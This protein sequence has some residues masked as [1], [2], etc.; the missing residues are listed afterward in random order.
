MLAQADALCLE[1]RFEEAATIYQQLVNMAESRLGPNHPDAILVLQRLADSL[2]AMNLFRDCLPLYE[3]LC[4][5]ARSMLGDGDPDVVNLMFKI[6]KTQELIGSFTEARATYQFAIN[7]AT[8]N[9]PPGHELTT[10]LRQ[11][12]DAL[13]QLME[14]NIQAAQAWKENT[15]TNPIITIGPDGRPLGPGKAQAPLPPLPQMPQQLPPGVAPPQST[16][17]PPHLQPRAQGLTPP[18]GYEPLPDA[19]YDSLIS[20]AAH[21]NGASNSDNSPAAQSSHNGGQQP[22]HPAGSPFGDQNQSAQA[23]DNSPQYFKAPPVMAGLSAPPPVM[24]ALTG[25]ASNANPWDP[26][27]DAPPPGMNDG[28]SSGGSPS[29]QP[30]LPPMAQSSGMQPPLSESPEIQAPAYAGPPQQMPQQPPPG[31]PPLPQQMPFPPQPQSLP[32]QHQTLPPQQMQ[33]EMQQQNLPSQQPTVPPHLMAMAIEMQQKNLSA[34]QQTVPP[35]QMPVEMQQQ[36]N[37]PGQQQTVPPHLMPQMQSAL[38]SQQISP[39]QFPQMSQEADSPFGAQMQPPMGGPAPQ[40]SQQLPPPQNASPPPPS[41][42]GRPPLLQPGMMPGFDSSNQLPGGLPNAI[43][44]GGMQDPWNA[45]QP[46]LPPQPWNAQNETSSSSIGSQLMQELEFDDMNS[47]Q[48]SLNLPSVNSPPGS[49]DIGA[50]PNMMP[51]SGNSNPGYGAQNGPRSGFPP[52]PQSS[53]GHGDAGVMQDPFRSSNEQDGLPLGPGPFPPPM[54]QPGMQPGMQYPG[55]Q[56]PGMQQPGMQQPGMQQPGM[57]QPGMQQPNM[58]QPVMPQSGM[59]QPGMHQGDGMHQSGVQH[60]TGFQQIGM[61][62]SPRQSGI[63]QRGIFTGGEP[64]A[65]RGSSVQGLGQSASPLHQ[66]GMVKGGPLPINDPFAESTGRKTNPD[67]YLE[68]LAAKVADLKAQKAEA[69]APEEPHLPRPGQPRSSGWHDAI[70]VPPERNQSQEMHRKKGVPPVLYE[71]ATEYGEMEESEVG[72]ADVRSAVQKKV[73]TSRAAVSKS[74][75]L[76]SNVRA[77]KEYL[78]P[79]VVLLVVGIGGYFFISA[80]TSRTPSKV[81]H[82]VAAPLPGKGAVEKKTVYA[83]P[84]NTMRLA[85][86]SRDC[87]LVDGKTLIN[88]PCV[89]YDGSWNHAAMQIIDSV[90]EKQ[91]WFNKMPEGMVMENGTILFDTKEPDRLVMERMNAMSLAANASYL[92]GSG[93]PTKKAQINAQAFVYPNPFTGNTEL[94]KLMNLREVHGNRKELLDSLLNGAL[95]LGEPKFGRGDVRVYSMGDSSSGVEKGLGFFVRGADRNGNLFRVS[96]TGQSVVLGYIEGKD[97]SN[98]HIQGDT[99]PLTPTTPEKPTKVWIAKGQQLPIFVIYHSLPI[100]M[101]IIAFLAF[102]RS[103]MVAPGQDPNNSANTTFRMIAYGAVGI[104]LITA[105]I[106]YTFWM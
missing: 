98:C 3:R 91:I 104:G 78:I 58:Q 35:Q 51:S 85:V 7:T 99:A 52:L 18:P 87:S 11:R 14:E 82:I 70:T 37:L 71:E 105:A 44:P 15:V 62:P 21:L 20:V 49:Q 66:A 34:Q 36:Q 27:P 65:M 83:T 73:V 94:V 32:M 55:M 50:A 81:E 61:Q 46:P 59:S 76:V 6:A 77:F 74:E 63:H 93:Y 56:H 29:S 48:S 17:L 95:V 39:P 19:T 97:V 40:P 33:M 101:A 53:P 26:E 41:S 5:V 28:F 8:A 75:G 4:T 54:N 38:N 57:Q 102:W 90:L 86:G 24:S 1:R 69:E 106:Q 16:Q 12:Y 23:Q 45:G 89:L 68:H 22:V 88:V 31:M 96:D 103:L 42:Q 67:P 9:L 30:S 2:Y 25:P 80:T 43:G 79:V 72:S 13:I 64:V 60:Q 100:S 47:A 10:Q 84:D 92:R